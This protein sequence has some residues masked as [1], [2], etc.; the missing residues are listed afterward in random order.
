MSITKLPESEE[1]TKNVIITRVDNA[2][3]IWPR[4]R[5]ASVLKREVLRLVETA[6]EIGSLW[7]L[8]R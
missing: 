2:M 4:G 7:T 3:V 8:S 1:V 5:Y 6:A